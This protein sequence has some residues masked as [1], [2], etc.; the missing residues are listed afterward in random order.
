VGDILRL[1][2]MSLSIFGMSDE[3][4]N[5]DEREILKK[6]GVFLDDIP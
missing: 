4:E 2:E 1:P 5:R 6:I 3:Q